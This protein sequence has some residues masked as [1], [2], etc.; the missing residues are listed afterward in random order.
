MSRAILAFFCWF[1]FR[2]QTPTNVFDKAPPE[3][4][5]ALRARISKFYQ[6]HVDGKARQAE[7]Y[8]AEDTKDFFFDA[9]KPHYFDFHIDK[10]T[11][12]DNFTKAKA[13]VM[14]NQR[15]MMPGALTEPIDKATPS[16][17]KLEDGKWFCMSI[18]PEGWRFRSGCMNRRMR[19]R[20]SRYRNRRS[21]CRC[22]PV[23][24]SRTFG[25]A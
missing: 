18:S 4:D 3:V 5:E 14:C 9:N 23:P 7:Q 22:L 12:S 1:L 25:T 19:C 10:I 15:I 11:Y 8:V 2:A 6:A 17:W 24:V 21:H 13:I 16:T 20:G